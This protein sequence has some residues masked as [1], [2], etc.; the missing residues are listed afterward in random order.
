[1]IVSPACVDR[2]AESM[3]L[4][5]PSARKLQPYLR[6]GNTLALAMLEDKAISEDNEQLNTDAIA[7]FKIPRGVIK[8]SDGRAHSSGC[9]F[10]GLHLFMV[11]HNGGPSRPIVEGR[12]DRILA[13]THTLRQAW[14]EEMRNPRGCYG[15]RL[16]F[17]YPG[18]GETDPDMFVVSDLVLTAVGHWGNADSLDGEFKPD[19]RLVR[20]HD[21]QFCSLTNLRHEKRIPHDG[22]IVS[23]SFKLGEDHG[24]GILDGASQAS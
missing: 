10:V 8:L 21:L 20:V 19:G 9:A 12:F 24:S 2:F 3:S 17:G 16:E 6:S 11:L 13:A 5:V 1:M 18:E 23:L 4:R 7:H 22:T 14:S 15:N